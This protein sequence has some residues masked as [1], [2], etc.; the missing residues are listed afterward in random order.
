MQIRAGFHNGSRLDRRRLCLQVRPGAETKTEAGGPARAGAAA[1]AALE[2]TQAGGRGTLRV[3]RG[4]RPTPWRR[5]SLTH[6][7]RRCMGAS[8]GPPRSA[9]LHGGRRGGTSCNFNC[10]LGL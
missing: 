6:R 8:P 9:S 7:V 2:Q 4:F 5:S 1:Q 10:M 3:R